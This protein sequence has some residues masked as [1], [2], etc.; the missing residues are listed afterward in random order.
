MNHTTPHEETNPPF[1]SVVK[2][3]TVFQMEYAECGAA[4][5]SII[6]GYYGRY[7]PLEQLREECGISRDGCKASNIVRAAEKEGLSAQGF[8]RSLGYLKTTAPPFIVFWEH[9]H[10]VVVEGFKG[11][12]VYINDPALGRMTYDIHSF[13]SSYSGIVLCFEK[14]PKFKKQG[15]PNRIIPQLLSRLKNEK[16]NVLFISYFAILSAALALVTPLFGKLFVDYFLIENM[17]SIIRIIIIG[18]AV[19]TVLRI[20]ASYLLNHYMAKF[21]NK[22]TIMFTSGFFWKLLQLPYS[23]FAHRYVGDIAQRVELNRVI[24]DFI[25]N[26]VVGL[27]ADCFVIILYFLLMVYLDIEITLITLFMASINGVLLYYVAKIRRDLSFKKTIKVS[28]YYAYGY[29]ALRNIESLKASGGEQEAFEKVSGAEVAVAN[30]Q[31]ILDRKSL[32]YLLAPTILSNLNSIIVLIL[33]AYKVMSGDMSIGTLVALQSIVAGF[34]QPVAKICLLMTHVQEM[35]GSIAKIDDVAQYQD[36]NKKNQ[37]LQKHDYKKMLS[38]PVRLTGRI[39]VSDLSYGYNR[40]EKPILQKLSFDIMPGEHVAFVG[41]SGSGKTTLTKLLAYLLIAWEGEILFDRQKP[42][43]LHPFI[44]QNSLS[45]VEQQGF[46]FNCKIRENITLWDNE[47]SLK[48]IITVAKAVGIHEEVS[49]R[50]HGYDDVILEN[51]AN[52]S[53]GQ[54]QRF[55]LARAL[56]NE[57]TILILDEATSELDVES[58]SK[59]IDHL[60]LLGCTTLIAAHRLSTVQHADKIIVLEAGKIIASGKHQ[61]LMN[62]C[63]YYHRM[64]SR[65]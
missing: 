56:I 39:T 40:F 35:A 61:S 30:A 65:E 63:P 3:P 36:I 23:F 20:L 38:E 32:S 8:K 26:N 64:M 46:L 7:I 43:D 31:H 16:N 54:R 11:N 29:G 34:I 59:I 19:T 24:S 58:E 27:L 44:L 52:F 4:A 14:T 6:L 37:S 21:Q 2:T 45:L 22:L 28:N 5:L 48:K 55:E 33:G 10:F 57:P 12:Q 42:N 15:K 47:V 50:P 25:S 49:L 60:R 13:E 62:N 17:M 53:G 1:R 51:G 18:I 9:N 41:L